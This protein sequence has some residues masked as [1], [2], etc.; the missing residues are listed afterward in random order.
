[1]LLNKKSKK[2]EDEERGSHPIQIVGNRFEDFLCSILYNIFTLY[3]ESSERR[4]K[5]YKIKEVCQKLLV[6][7]IILFWELALNYLYLYIRKYIRNET[8]T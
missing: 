5:W 8:H 4:G 2:V 1:M 6:A 7:Y 3:V